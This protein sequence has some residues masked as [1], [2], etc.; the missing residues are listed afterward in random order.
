MTDDLITSYVRCCIPDF[1]TT[2]DTILTVPNKTLGY[3]CKEVPLEFLE[4][5]PFKLCLE[6]FEK[7]L[8][9]T[10]NAVGLAAPQVGLNYCFFAIARSLVKPDSGLDEFVGASAET[11]NVETTVCINPHIINLE[12]VPR[13][14]DEGCLSLPGITGRVTRWPVIH[15]GWLDRTGKS[16]ADKFEGKLA[17]IWQHETDHLQ[18]KLFIDKMNHSNRAKLLKKYFEGI[19]C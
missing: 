11:S 10:P 15:A 1:P 2:L 16:K 14:V 4:D 13:T 12:G 17:Q 6:A 5:P 19:T 7:L 3:K 18:G 8:G 9:E